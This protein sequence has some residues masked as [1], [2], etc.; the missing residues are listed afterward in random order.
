MHSARRSSA[1]SDS[2]FISESAFSTQRTKNAL[3]AT[4]AQAAFASIVSSME[5]SIAAPMCES[6]PPPR[7]GT[8]QGTSFSHPPK[9]CTPQ[10]ELHLLGRLDGPSVVPTYIVK[11][12]RSYRHAVRMA[13]EMRRVAY[14]TQRQLAAEAGLNYRHVS[15]YLH[16]DDKPSR[17][18]LPPEQLEEFNAAV[19]NTLTTQYLAA[20]DKLTVL[21]EQIANKEAA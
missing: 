14:M 6:F 1:L 5:Q 7:Q 12:C 13:W 19:G 21:E 15:D 9:E 18:S 4:S 3:S 16:A 17:R 10:R 8:Q 2:A 20:R 11:Q